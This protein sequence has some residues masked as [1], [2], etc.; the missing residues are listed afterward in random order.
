MG[1]GRFGF[2]RVKLSMLAC[3]ALYGEHLKENVHT[4]IGENNYALAA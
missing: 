4:I 1:W 2:D 3:S